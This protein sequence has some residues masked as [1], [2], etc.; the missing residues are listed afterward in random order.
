MP[1]YLIDSLINL[2]KTSVMIMV[3]LAFAIANLFLDND[4]P[5]LPSP[6][7]YTPDCLQINA[8]SMDAN[9]SRINVA[10]QVGELNEFPSSAAIRLIR[11]IVLSGNSVTYYSYPNFRDIKVTGNKITFN[12]F[13][14]IGGSINASLM[15]QSRNLGIFQHQIN[16]I[17][18]F[19]AGY[20]RIVMLPHLVGELHD[21]CFSNNT[22]HYFSQPLTFIEPM[23]AT[24]DGLIPFYSR[25]MNADEFQ[26]NNPDHITVYKSTI[27]ISAAPVQAWRQLSDILLPMWGSLYTEY[28]KVKFSAYLTQNQD[29]IIP[30][31]KRLI[32]DSIM[33]NN[34]AGCFFDGHF[35]R[36]PGSIPLHIN[37]S[38]VTMENI[39]LFSH[40][41]A[42]IMD[43]N[44][45]II[46]DFR[47]LFTN[48]PM[49]AGRILLD[50]TALKWK[51]WLVKAFPEND[52]VEL[53]N[54]ETN[55]KTIAEIADLVSSSQI[56]IGTH[57]SSL[58]FG[59]FMSKGSTMLEIQP[60]G[61]ECTYFGKSFADMS[62]AK[63]VPLSIEDECFNDNILKYFEQDILDYN[64]NKNQ[65][66]KTFKKILL[67]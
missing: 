59:I 17:N 46:A 6:L 61:C 10:V 9:N 65:L 38:T 51:K 33:L 66:L 63:Y 44:R 30:N 37:S 32:N 45:N 16:D 20:S 43:I 11:I 40:H 55:E 41:F 15:C 35:I 36:S 2:Y 25:M 48:K 27:F 47:H 57:V 28:K 42:W 24:F 22:I 12:I 21:F 3:I 7:S 54:I 67:S 4:P 31:I 18:Y 34:T 23:H 56:F 58:I 8:I 1:T 60:I 49:T 19:T 39:V 62:G 64:V 5:L 26:N 29:W 53:P 14:Q 52:Y 13:Q 50:H